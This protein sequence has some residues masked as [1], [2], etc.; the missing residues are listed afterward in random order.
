MKQEIIDKMRSELYN[1]NLCQKDFEKYDVETL[2][3]TNEPFLWMVRE[4]GTTLCNIGFSKHLKLFNNECCR[5]VIMRDKIALIQSILYWNDPS[6]KYFYYDGWKLHRIIKEEVRDIYMN[7]YE[8]SINQMIEEHPEE[9][10]MAI[11]P[12]KLEI[13]ESAREALE[14]AKEFADSLNDTSLKDCLNRLTIYSRAAI[15]HVIEIYRDCAKYSFGFAERINGEYRI[16]GGIIYAEYRTEKR[17]QIH[18]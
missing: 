4:F 2:A 8:A 11:Q 14:K 18:T 12:L 15:D 3:Q 1:T 17:W 10:N 7:V 5:M 13:R 6:A 9:A 16:C